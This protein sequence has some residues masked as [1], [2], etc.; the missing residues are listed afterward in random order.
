[1]LNN[2]INMPVLGLGVYMTAPGRETR[3][4]VAWAL[5]AGY[6]H[7]D[8]ARFYDNERDV[9][10]AVR[11]SGLRREQ[12]FVTTKLWNSDHGYDAAQ[13]ALD[14]S[15]RDLGL[16]YVDLFLIHWP[17]KGPGKGN[18]PGLSPE[19][20]R[21]SGGLRLE[22]WKALEQLLLNGSCLAIGVSN[23]TIRHL[24]ELMEASTVVPAVNQVEFSPFLYQQELLEFCRRNNIQLEAYSPLTRGRRLNHPAL[25]AM[26]A[27]YARTAAQI[28]IRWAIQHETVVIPKS[29]RRKRIIENARVFDFSISPEDMRALDAL[30][31]NL[32]ICWDP[33]AAP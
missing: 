15:L 5:E 8:T 19:H 26:A 2:G 20:S 24:E 28:L 13:R 9:G 14:A 4:A 33:T 27:R 25:L 7:I 17:V 3:D 31:E 32:R 23:Y 11:E 22:T 6:R 30:N 1:M 16:D 21:S 10:L 18:V 12:I 29:A